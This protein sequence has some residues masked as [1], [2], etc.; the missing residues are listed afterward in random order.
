MSHPEEDQADRQAF[1]A[2]APGSKAGEV[3]YVLLGR[4]SDDV[5]RDLFD[6]AAGLN[7]PIRPEY[8]YLIGAQQIH[9]GNGMP[10]PEMV[11]AWA[12][13]ADS[14][15]LTSDSILENIPK[16]EY[17]KKIIENGGVLLKLVLRE[18]GVENIIK[19]R[20][21]DQGQTS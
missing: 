11:N 14:E 2:K 13:Q 20:K 15:L 6:V 12:D 4:P 3:A 16:E 5:L 19:K 7:S 8:G 9:G 1:E 10:I 21:R 18:G 17:A